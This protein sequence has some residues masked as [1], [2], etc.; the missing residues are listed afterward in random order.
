MEDIYACVSK[1]K[2]C[3]DDPINGFFSIPKWTKHDLYGRIDRIGLLQKTIGPLVISLRRIESVSSV[4]GRRM[5]ISHE[6]DSP[7]VECVD[8]CVDHLTFE[9]WVG[10]EKV[11]AEDVITSLRSIWFFGV[12]FRIVFFQSRFKTCSDVHNLDKHSNIFAVLF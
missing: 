4:D 9:G 7:V 12:I 1:Q 11:D 2:F 5:K 8:V 6:L 10:K 3:I